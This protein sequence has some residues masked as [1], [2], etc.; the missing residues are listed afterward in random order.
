MIADR[1][2]LG[3]LFGACL[4]W[5]ST[6]DADALNLLMGAKWSDTRP[7]AGECADPF[8]FE[9]N[10]SRTR[11]TV[12]LE[13]PVPSRD[14]TGDTFHYQI[15]EVHETTVRMFLEHETLRDDSGALVEWWL[16]HL[17]PGAFAWRRSDWQWWMLTPTR[18][19]CLLPG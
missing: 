18:H 16:V 7:Q 12:R 8:W 15:R 4:I 14:I 13:T 9:L 3:G 2:H 5:A 11:L 19:R 1:S 6:A 17:G 10:Q